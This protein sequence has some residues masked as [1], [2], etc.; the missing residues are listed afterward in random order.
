MR[1]ISTLHLIIPMLQPTI[2]RNE[3]DM[4][5]THIILQLAYII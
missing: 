4:P 1:L 2:E 5:Q 3:N